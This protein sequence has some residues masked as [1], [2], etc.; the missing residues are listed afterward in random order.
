M[1]DFGTV[2]LIEGHPC[3]VCVLGSDKRLVE[4]LHVIGHSDDL[5]F[6]SDAEVVASRLVAGDGIN[7]DGFFGFV[8]GKIRI[9]RTG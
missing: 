2:G 6:R 1:N 9:S 4:D 7:N 5:F 3:A 8:L